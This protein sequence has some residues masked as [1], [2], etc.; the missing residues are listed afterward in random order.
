[1]C[2][3]APF[4][5]VAVI[6]IKYICS[7]KYLLKQKR[8]GRK[9]AAL[10]HLCGL[11]RFMSQ[12][13]KGSLFFLSLRTEWSCG[14]DAQAPSHSSPSPPLPLPPPPPPATSI[15]YAWVSAPQVTL[16]WGSSL[17][18]VSNTSHNAAFFWTDYM[19][20]ITL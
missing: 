19:M 9:R 1:M 8:K 15:T 11:H 14:N 18:L 2:P 7:F 17:A 4:T 5:V 10:C 13:L 6:I 12:F 3:V 16:H 20:S